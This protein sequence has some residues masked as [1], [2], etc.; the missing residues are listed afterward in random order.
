MGEAGSDA[1]KANPEGR[2]SG[3]AGPDLRKLRQ[4]IQYIRDTVRRLEDIRSESKEA[5]LEKNILQAAATR[6]LQVGVE[7][8]LDAAHHIIAREGLGIPQTYR[9]A[10]RLLVQAG[11]L[12]RDRQEVYLRMVKFRNRAVHLYDEIEPREI[13]N[14]LENH[15]GDF[16]EVIRAL[17]GRYFEDRE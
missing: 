16:E 1:A 4:K 7:A 2:G 14:L 8:I 15:L 12:P 9:E 6:H 17:V 3:S 11:I 10:I 13:W 5:F